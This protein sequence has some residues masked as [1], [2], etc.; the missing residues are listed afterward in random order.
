MTTIPLLSML[1]VSFTLG[2]LFG[3]LFDLRSSVLRESRQEPR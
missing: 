2:W 1:P 3:A